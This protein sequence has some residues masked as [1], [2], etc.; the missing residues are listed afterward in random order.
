MWQVC[1]GVYVADFCSFSALA[2]SINGISID[3]LIS[4]ATAASPRVMSVSQPVAYALHVQPARACATTS[5]A[6]V[7]LTAMTA[8]IPITASVTVRDSFGNLR[9][10]NSYSS[11]SNMDNV[12]AFM[13]PLPA[14][15]TPA[16]NFLNGFI[17]SGT[18]APVKRAEAAP[19]PRMLQLYIAL[20]PL[21]HARAQDRPS[22]RA[23]PL[24][25]AP[26]S[27]TSSREIG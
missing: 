2:I 22:A 1:G 25:S 5:T 15:P 20:P 7:S 9:A 6:S 17:P 12:L 3:T 8:G 16:K 23:A 10:Q 24:K 21:P 14:P 27:C 18:T 19:L 13:F 4:T 26:L 11:V